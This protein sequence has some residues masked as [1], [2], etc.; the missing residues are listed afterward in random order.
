[1]AALQQVADVDIAPDGRWRPALASSGAGGASGRAGAEEAWVEPGAAPAPR[2]H[3][4]VK[5]EPGEGGRWVRAE[6]LGAGFRGW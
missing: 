3:V 1:M 6:G 2:P 5:P 4:A